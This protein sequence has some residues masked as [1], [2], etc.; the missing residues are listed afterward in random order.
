MPL[1]S[2]GYLEDKLED[3]EDLAKCREYETKIFFPEDIKGEEKH[4]TKGKAIEVCNNC[5]VMEYC[6]EYAIVNRIP[7]GI[8]GG[9]DFYGRV[10]LQQAHPRR[11]DG[12]KSSPSIPGSNFKKNKKTSLGSGAKNGIISI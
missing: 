9:L 3:W 2:V 6:L 5:Q 4:K 8:W 7:H 10:R 11:F 1:L 12:K